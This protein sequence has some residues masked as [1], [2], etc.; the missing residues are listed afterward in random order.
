LTKTIKI[1]QGLLFD[2]MGGIAVTSLMICTVSG[3]FLAIPYSVR[4]PLDS[5]SLI[6]L[7]NPAAAFI[8][9]IHYWSAQ[10]FFIFTILHLTDHFLQT[11]EY[12]VPKGIWVRLTLSIPVIFFVMI[13]GFILK[14]D[15]D[16]YSAHRILS[17]LIEKIPLAGNLLRSSF[18]GNENDLELVYVHHIATGTII[19]FIILF[20][21]SRKIWPA[22]IGFFI[23]LFIILLFSYLIHPA[24]GEA[25]GKG[26]WYFAGLQEVLHWL[27]KPGWAWLIILA[28]VVI[29]GII[30][31]IAPVHNRRFKLT[32]VI[33]SGLYILLTLNA[34]FFR[35]ENWQ[36]KWPWQNEQAGNGLARIYPLILKTPEDFGHSGNIPSISGQ[37]EG[38]LVCHFN[39]T[40]LMPAHDPEAIGCYSC[41]GGDPLTLNKTLAHSRMIR[42]PG[43]LADAARSCGTAS[44]HP[45]IPARV[46]NSIMSTMSGVVTV[47]R[48]VFGESDSLNLKAH[49]RDI[50][51]SAA[52][53][54]LRDLCANC[55]MGNPK[56]EYGPVTQLSRGG[57]CNACHLNY[58]D[59]ALVSLTLS[60]DRLKS[61]TFYHP[62]L[63]L[64]ISDEHCFGCHSRS[65]RISLNYGGW[66]ETLL[67]GEDIPEE[68][69][70]KTLDDKRVLEYIGE[71]IH[72]QKGMTCIDCH[73]S[74]ELMGDGQLFAHKEE[75]LK[76][77]CEDCHFS[78]KAKTGRYPDFNAESKKI[79]RQRGWMPGDSSYILTSANSLPLIN[80]WLDDEGN[81]VLR[82]KTGN[83][84]LPMLPPVEACT[85]G[86]VHKSLSCESCHSSW[87]PQCIGCHNTFDRE[88]PGFDMLEGKEK[89]GSWIE[90]VALFMADKPTLGIVS[91]RDGSKSVKTFAPGMVLSIDTTTF[92]ADEPGKSNIFRRLYAPSSAHTTVREGRSCKSCHLDPLAIGYGRGE[93]EYLMEGKR[94][95]WVFHNRFALNKYDQLP[96]DAW[97]GFLSEPSGIN[98]TRTNARPFSMKEQQ[99]ILLVGACLL[100]H[101][102]DSRIMSESLEDFPA[103]LKRVSDQCVLPVWN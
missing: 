88:A 75:Q 84:I 85:R 22:A 31:F 21:H 4:E 93:L 18:L 97:I 24:I 3:I 56:T 27:S 13:T 47:D 63:N 37:K 17:S 89:K 94:G 1:L 38:C 33:L 82:V 64:N 34:I 46:S 29:I 52:D 72:H 9:N 100:C 43:N 91:D 59:S 32:L 19:L 98:S 83:E 8:R 86:K 2:T 58:S 90:H 39:V 61:G 87:V 15:A 62:Q 67:E 103:L 70:F 92:K 49:I 12:L 74:A 80:C 6:L 25:T 5:I 14:G 69:R 16:A 73:I 96:E 66:H 51:H 68:G 44:C 53:Q 35:G 20:E 78:G 101:S 23:L 76:I 7:D 45:D 79:I 41:H 28:P 50:D 65:G 71:D 77:R 26:P 48:F 102:E 10:F 55:H 60:D 95:T 99:S 40:G 36:W 54:H 30:R 11:T 57:G 42:I 81:A